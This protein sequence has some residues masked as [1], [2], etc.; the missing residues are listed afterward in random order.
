MYNIPSTAGTI[1]TPSRLDAKNLALV[2]VGALGIDVGVVLQELFKG[3]PGGRHDVCAGIVVVNLRNQ[4]AV[5]ALLRK[6]DDLA[7]E[8]VRA[9]LVD[10]TFVNFRQ[11]IRRDTLK[12]R[13][14]VAPV[15]RLNSVLFQAPRDGCGGSQDGHGRGDE[16]GETKSSRDHCWLKGS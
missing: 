13:D 14:L 15:T 11:L 12:L 4:V 5:K 3:D 7:R 2:N 10:D 6:T 1:R 8:D 16:H 9:S